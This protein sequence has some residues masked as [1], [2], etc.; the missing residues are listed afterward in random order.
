M[1]T[2]IE[3]KSGRPFCLCETV[4]NAW[5][6]SVRAAWPLATDEARWAMEFIRTE[7]KDRNGE[8]FVEC[9]EECR[10]VLCHDGFP[11]RGRRKRDALRGVDFAHSFAVANRLG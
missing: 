1:F 6:W 3:Y 4:R 11:L 7:L 9:V 10:R 2:C 8:G 5:H